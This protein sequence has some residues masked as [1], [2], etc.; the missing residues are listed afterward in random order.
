[1]NKIF[2]FAAIAALANAADEWKDCTKPDSSCDAGFK[3]DTE[4]K[5]S[6]IGS[7]ATFIR[8]ANDK[9]L[10]EATINAAIEANRVATEKEEGMAKEENSDS[11]AVTMQAGLA[12]AAGL[13][14]ALF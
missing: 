1:M 4:C 11:F 13:A 8:G 14:L 6:K 3:V 10:T 5:C 7:N 9:I 2:A 12:T